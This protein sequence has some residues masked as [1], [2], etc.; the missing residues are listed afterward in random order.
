MV[1]IL[2]CPDCDARYYLIGNF[3]ENEGR[4]IRASD[5][6]RL[7]CERCNELHTRMGFE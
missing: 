6:N 4:M 1:A 3:S 5:V 7:D 2:V